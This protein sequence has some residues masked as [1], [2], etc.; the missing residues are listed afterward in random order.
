MKSR[1]LTA[2]C[3]PMFLGF[4]AC[5]TTTPMAS[6]VRNE[7]VQVRED[8]PALKADLIDASM[9]Q[10]IADWGRRDAEA[11]FAA[12]AYMHMIAFDDIMNAGKCQGVLGVRIIYANGNLEQGGDRPYSMVALDPVDNGG[13]ICVYASSATVKSSS[14]VGY[15][16]RENRNFENKFEG[17]TGIKFK[18]SEA[19][20]K[21]TQKH[22]R[23]TSVT[24]MSLVSPAIPGMPEDPWLMVIGSSCGVDALVY[25][26]LATGAVLEGPRGVRGGC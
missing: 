26:N 9:I 16:V 19:L 21:I 3:I 8:L 10:K 17:V 23:F 4:V 11:M 1:H 2:F 24:G 25:V 14:D 22:G 15:L 20:T 12:K 6:S 5:K 13:G 18:F 7:T